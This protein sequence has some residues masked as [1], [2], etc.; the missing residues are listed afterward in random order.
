MS[1]FEQR[2]EQAKSVY[3]PQSE[4]IAKT[5]QIM[6]HLLEGKF[7]DWARDF[8]QQAQGGGLRSSMPFM[9]GSNSVLDSSLRV[10]AAQPSSG[11]LRYRSW[12]KVNRQGRYPL[13]SQ[14]NPRILDS[15]KRLE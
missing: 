6:D 8:D 7:A 4:Q 13:C 15:T 3:F 14:S 11:F 10:G 2:L 9:E 12:C 5:D 1:K